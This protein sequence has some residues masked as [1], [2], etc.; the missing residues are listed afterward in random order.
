M[1]EQPTTSQVIYSLW[2][3]AKKN[4]DHAQ[5]T[6]AKVSQAAATLELSCER[7]PEA[8]ALRLDEKLPDAAAKAAT[9]IASR[10]TNA[11]AHADRAAKAYEEATKLAR[12]NIYGGALIVIAAFATGVAALAFW[13]LPN[14]DQI[15]AMR[16]EKAQLE[17]T[18]SKL[19]YDG[20]R[21]NVQP[22]VDSAGA[23]RLC[24]RI[25]ESAKIQGRGLKVIKGY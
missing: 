4:F 13:I 12:Q 14:H 21:A 19:T 17:A 25:D 5:A 3:A 7:L 1:S 18:L 6:H 9:A 15:V 11:N 10:W 20:A 8:I 24:I 2:N 23:A 16:M 22:C